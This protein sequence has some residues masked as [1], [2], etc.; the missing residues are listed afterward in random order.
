MPL[1]LPLFLQQNWLTKNLLEGC[2]RNLFYV[3]AHNFIQCS[4]GLPLVF[5]LSCPFTNCSVNMAFPRPY[6]CEELPPIFASIMSPFLYEMDAAKDTT[7]SSTWSMMKCLEHRFSKGGPSGPVY[8]TEEDSIRQDLKRKFDEEEEQEWASLLLDASKKQKVLF[9][10]P[11][12]PEG[13]KRK[14]RKTPPPKW[15]SRTYQASPGSSP[16]PSSSP[17]SQSSAGRPEE[18]SPSKNCAE[19]R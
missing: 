18:T 15:F 11:A 16:C 14:Y 8:F 5:C 6:K 13:K 1:L 2:K 3:V 4:S 17:L 12:T 19:D 7:K 9:T 10:P